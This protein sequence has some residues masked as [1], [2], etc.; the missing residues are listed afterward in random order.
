MR[1][2]KGLNRAKECFGKM[3]LMG[4]PEQAKA[5]LAFLTHAAL[6]KSQISVEINARTT[7]EMALLSRSY[8]LGQDS[9]TI[10]TSSNHAERSKYLFEASLKRPCEM[11]I[12]EPSG[13]S[14]KR[15]SREA[16][17]VLRAKTFFSLFS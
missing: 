14:E 3:L 15:A 2:L 11:I 16:K 12:V 7:A 6:S 1:T 8:A 9:V 13:V 4:T 10:V 17:K 5:M